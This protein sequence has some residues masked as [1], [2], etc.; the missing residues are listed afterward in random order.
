MYDMRLRECD[1]KEV[2]YMRW[3]ALEASLVAQESM[4]VDKEQR[5]AAISP[6]L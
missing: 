4:Y 5:S 2:M 6:G 3:E 1:R